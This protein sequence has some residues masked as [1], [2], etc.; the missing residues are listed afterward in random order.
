MVNQVFITN[1]ADLGLGGK[2][3]ARVV[4]KLQPP[5]VVSEG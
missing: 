2:E 1:V 4:R 3:D 5:T